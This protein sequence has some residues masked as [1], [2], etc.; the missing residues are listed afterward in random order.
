MHHTKTASIK[1]TVI[2]IITA[3]LNLSCVVSANAVSEKTYIPGGMPFGAKIYTDGVIISAFTEPSDLGCDKN[4]A[5]NSGLR[6]GD[7][8]KKI[9]GKII[10]TPSALADII[11]N[12]SGNVLNISVI[13]GEKEETFK[14]KPIKCHDGEYRI[15][16]NV[17]DSMA[18]IGTVTFISCE[19]G[20]FGG[21]GHGIC[22]SYTSCVIPIQRG[23]VNGVKINNIIK[24]TEGKPG[25]IRGSFLMDRTGTL[26]K[27]TEC[28]VFGILSSVPNN[29]NAIP[30]ADISEIKTGAATIRCTLDNEGIKSYSIEIESIDKDTSSSTKNFQIKITDKE[31]IEKTGG[32]IQGM[33][34]SPI[35]QNGK[36]VGAITHVMVN[37]PRKGYG[38]YIGNML[39]QVPALLT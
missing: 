16:V 13:R 8:I 37:D 11:D 18:G 33:S 39:K 32:I 12:C 24:G 36:L 5:L 38:I 23:S 29:V 22:D 7:V 2:F 31:L 27:N 15:G 26:L 30:A 21:L 6:C 20:A 1:R 14:V 34:G 28:G 3:I 4:P 19:S 17:R 10:K 35:I 25:E 9:D